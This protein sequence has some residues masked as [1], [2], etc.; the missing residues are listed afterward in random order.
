MKPQ[1]IKGTTYIR[2]KSILVGSESRISENGTIL[3][4]VY[5]FIC[6]IHI[7]LGISSFAHSHWN[8][9]HAV[10]GWENELIPRLMWMKQI[11]S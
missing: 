7:S 4:N 2:A 10:V 5:D 9:E 6:F 11:K 8:L 3:N 1:E